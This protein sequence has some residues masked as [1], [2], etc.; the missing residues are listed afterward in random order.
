MKKRLRKLSLRQKLM[1][2]YCFFL[3]L[4]IAI[5]F[6]FYRENISNI[7]SDNIRYMQQINSQI[8]STLD[9]VLANPSQLNYIQ[10][11]DNKY[12]SILRQ[13]SFPAVSS[14]QQENIRY[15][16]NTLKHAV[17][18]NPYIVR[19][20]ILS[21]NQ[22]YSTVTSDFQSYQDTILDVVGRTNWDST[23]KTIYT[24]VFHASINQQ[25]YRI[26]TML[27]Y[28]YDYN[29]KNLLGLLA[30]DIDYSQ[31]S[32]AL[33]NSAEKAEGRG[34]AVLSE[35]GVIYQSPSSPLS[36]K[37]D[38][39]LQERLRTASQEL[40]NGKLPSVDTTI[41]GERYL[42]TAAKSNTSNWLI[43]LFQSKVALFND[44][45]KNMQGALLFMLISSFLFIGFSYF[46]ATTIS[47]PLELIDRTIRKNQ[48]GKLT[49]IPLEKPIADND[50]GRVIKNYNEM[51]QRLN[52]NMRNKIIYEVSK[53]KTQLR[54]LRYQINPHFIYNTLNTINSIGE[55]EGVDS[56]CQVTGS[57]S[58]IMRYNVKGGD[59]VTVSQELQNARDY[60][61][62]QSIRF[63]GM[64]HTVFSVQE[65]TKSLTM[66]KFLLQP[67]L[68]N[69]ISHGLKNTRSGGKIL[70]D[71]RVAA[72]LL[73]ITICDN[74][75]Q[76]KE[77]QAEN[78]NEILK[79][80]TAD[81]M[82]DDPVD[83]NWENI[84]LRNVNA[85]IKS[86]YGNE[87]GIHIEAAE[88]STTKVHLFLRTKT[89]DL[90]KGGKVQT[91]TGGNEFAE[92]ISCR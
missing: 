5:F 1:T 38:F 76:I 21:N 18:M 72:D 46:L 80:D 16:E 63:P 50:M 85:R 48:G 91:E 68:E 33:D 84:G 24:E 56:V 47:Q 36:L 45:T 77:V 13:N 42:L 44:A 90:R 55:I 81:L 75:G 10:F 35:S 2:S 86:Y 57:L 79:N 8:D 66:L 3:L 23:S 53:Q 49:P 78:W 51:T 41:A 88:N 14:E 19:A 39:Q 58:R 69:A 4:I 92:N 52:E 29:S 73:Q 65:E 28:L 27:K 26:M 31:I 67:I 9:A 54:M 61:A 25:Q 82:M 17:F 22:F 59:V 64:F 12:R 7:Q 20:S 43:L 74:G 15:I 62:I 70:V 32:A 87:Y 89:E 71:I 60:L 40:L 37:E 83:G 11:Y 30:V 34:V 6:F